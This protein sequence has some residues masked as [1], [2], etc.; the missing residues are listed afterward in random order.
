MRKIIIHLFLLTSLL[1]G[2]IKFDANFESGNLISA[3]TSDSINY[4]ATAKSDIGG[5][6]FYFRISGVK[7]KFIKV[8]IVD[9]SKIA[10][11]VTR[12]M[13]SYDNISFGRFTSS[14]SPRKGT[15][16]KTFEQDTVYVSYYTPY[17][18]KYLEERINELLK[19]SFVKV[20]TLGLTDHNMPIQEII[21]TDP[22]YPDESKYQVWIHARTHPGET[23]SSWH[24]DGIIRTLLRDDD[25]ISFYRKN[26]VFHLIPFTNPEGVFYGRSRTNFNGVDVESNWGQ[27]ESNTSTEVKILK[28]RMADLNN[29]KPFSVFLNLHSQASPFCTMWIHTPTS[30]TDIFYR[31]EIQIANLNS[32]DNPYFVQKDY[33]QSSLQNYFPEGWQWKNWGSNIMAL[34]YETPY[35]Q[36]SNGVLVTN[37]NLFDIGKRTVYAIAEYLNLSQ[38][39]YLILDNKD[40]VVTGNWAID[41]SGVQFYGDNYLQINS[42]IGSDS[43]SYQTQNLNPG[44]YDIY[45]WWPAKSTYAYNTKFHI[46]SEGHETVIEKTQQINGGQWN[47]LKQVS[48]L[49]N[50]KISLSINNNANGIVAVDAF[51]IIYN[52]PVASVKDAQLP[53]DFVLYQNFPNPFNPSTTIRFDLRKRSKV[54]LRIIDALGKQVAILLNNE[55]EAGTHN[56]FFNTAKYPLLGSGVY[57]FILTTEKFSE[58]KGMVLVK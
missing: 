9:E 55:V 46:K 42:G 19:S 39:K 56:V 47:F 14:E 43:V 20:D 22:S 24:F 26:I 3:T 16:Q 53:K 41:S 34:T 38:P 10:N 58:T 13:Y 40:M 35:D 11:D 2:Q 30:T 27:P 37:D 28:K 48:L 7:N 18:F 57:Y 17:T 36:Y 32:S 12:A 45:A 29:K 21:I 44:N 8:N 4:T 51:R 31:K 6:W 49:N 23:P 54:L 33:S 50:G 25:V 5:R 15:F 1:S 52:S